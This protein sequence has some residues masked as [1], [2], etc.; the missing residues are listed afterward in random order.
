MVSL[1]IISEESNDIETKQK[2]RPDESSGRVEIFSQTVVPPVLE[3][4]RSKE[5]ATSRLSGT[6]MQREKRD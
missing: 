6:D 3:I 4:R 1:S 2:A 5:R